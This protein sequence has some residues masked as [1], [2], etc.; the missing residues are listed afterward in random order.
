MLLVSAYLFGIG[1]VLSDSLQ[2]AGR[3]LGGTVSELI[4][5][6]TLASVLVV[7]WGSLDA[8]RFAVAMT[9]AAGA[10]LVTLAGIAYFRMERPKT[11]GAQA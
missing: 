3:P 7:L 11:P 8:F 10:A 9:F 5:G 2:G 6:L 1:R 4:A